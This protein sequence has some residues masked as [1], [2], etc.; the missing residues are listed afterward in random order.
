MDGLEMSAPAAPLATRKSSTRAAS[1]SSRQSMRMAA[2]DVG[3]NSIHMIVAEADVD[4]GLATLG[5]M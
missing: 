2:I 4:G 3:T 1:S 5:R